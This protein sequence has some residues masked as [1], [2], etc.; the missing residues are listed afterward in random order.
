MDVTTLK[1]GLYEVLQPVIG[2]VVVWADQNSARPNLPYTVFK[3]GVVNLIGGAHYSDPDSSG[4]QTVLGYRESTL[5]IQRF[6][7]GSVGT[8]ETFASKMAFNSVL[9]KLYKKGISAFDISDVT[10]VAQLLN[11][12]AIEPRASIDVRV[13][14]ASGL[15]DNV[16]IIETV[17][18]G[19]VIGPDNTAKNQEYAITSVVVNL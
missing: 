13:R 17:N 11:G 2:G 14:W 5:N 19:G 18:A 7:A 4:N 12:L 8:L 10:D 9:D 16:G 1:T 3:L 15:L 6:G